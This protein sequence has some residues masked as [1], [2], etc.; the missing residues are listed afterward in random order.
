MPIYQY[1]CKKCDKIVEKEYKIGNAPKKTQC[2]DCKRQCERCFSPPM[3]QF[4]GAGF[5]TTDSRGS[6]GKDS[7]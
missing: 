6:Q 1:K 2:I 7:A 5:Y 3:I 4:V